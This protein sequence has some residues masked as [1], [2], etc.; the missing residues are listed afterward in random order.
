MTAIAAIQQRNP[1]LDGLRG[2]AI[3]WVVAFH[4]RALFGAS[5][6]S[7]L[8]SAQPGSA[9]ALAESGLLG[10]QLFF[11]L[12]GF[13]LALPWLRHAA[14][15]G[16]RPGLGGYFRRRAR[17][18]L[19]PLYLHLALLFGL[20]LPLL[21]GG[22][23]LLASQLGLLNL[24]AH[25]LLLHF[26]HPGSASSF[27]LN[28]ALWSLSIEAQFYLLLPWLVPWFTGRRAWPALAAALG[29]TLAWRLWAPAL[30]APWLI[31][32]IPPELLI[33]FD[34]VSGRAIPY[35]PPLLGLFVERQLPGECF[36]FAC[37]MAA[38]SL[39][40]RLEANDRRAPIWRP[41]GRLLLDHLALALLLGWAL[42]LSR[43]P[44]M[45]LITDPGWR[46]LGQ[47][48]LLVSLGLVVL[49]AH[50]QQGPS[51]ARPAGGAASSS[52]LG[53]LLGN[54][55]LAA[56]GL[57]SYSLFLWHEPV[58]RLARAIHEAAGSI[59]GAAAGALLSGLVAALMVALL[60]YLLTERRW[61]RR[62][63]P[64]G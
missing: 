43:L 26:L 13:L 46:L 20:V 12:S 57:I 53:R 8:G 58:L 31:T 27:G 6:G 33:Y 32:N 10:V 51:A 59:S 42:A 23:A 1:A 19:P 9:A 38:A 36:A 63:I 56:L 54:G 7:G 61:G 45:V 60:S 17:R 37:G 4:A 22:L 40:A 3:L 29:L 62:H 55:A 28:M 48:A 50:L 2:L 18:L 16:P 5:L 21:P 25:G 30:L 44:L 24:A 14:G 11:V 41:A 64:T 49:A 15:N 34:P 52:A 47:P 35:P 39:A